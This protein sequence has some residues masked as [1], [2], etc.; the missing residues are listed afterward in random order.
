METPPHQQQLTLQD[1]NSLS[2]SELASLTPAEQSALLQLID[3]LQAEE[4]ER[5]RSESRLANREK[6]AK[7][8][9]ALREIGEIPPVVD[10]A[11]RAECDA[12]LAAFLQTCFPD[13]FHLQFSAAHLELIAAV[14]RAVS[15][16]GNEAFACERGF[17]KTQISIGGALWGCLTGRVRYAMIIAANIDMATSQREGIKRRLET[18]QPLYDLYPEICYPMRTLAGSL[19]MSATYRG[20]LVRIRSRPD[21]V[22]PCIAGAPGSEAVIACTGI[23]SSSIRGRFYDRA[24]G[25]TARPDLVM[26]DDPQDDATARQPELVKKRSIKI[27]QAVTGMRGPGRKLAMLMPCTVIAKNDLADEF[28]DRQRRPEWSGRRIAAMPSMPLDLDAE[29]PLW[30]KYDELRRED[31]AMGDKTRQ[32]AT[33]FYLANREAMSAGAEITWP[34]RVEL[35]CVDALQALM[36]KYLSDRQ[37]FLAEQQQN[38]QGDEDVSAYLDFN[39]IVGRFNGLRRGQLPPTGSLLTTSIDVQEHLLYWL[40]ILWADD[41]SGWIVD[42]GTFPKQPVADFHHMQPPRTIHDWARKAFPRQGMT[43][44]EEHRAALEEC[45]RTLPQPEGPTPGPILVDNRWHKAQQ[46]VESVSTAPEFAGTVVP[47]GGIAVGGNDTAISARKMQ[48]GSKRVSKD[49]EWYIKREST[50]RKIL[51]FDANVYRSQLQKGI[52]EEP[53]KPGSI[54]YN[55]PFADPILASHLASKSV[56]LTVDTKRELEIWTNKPGQDQDHWL[57]C[58]VMCRVAAELAGLRINGAPVTKPQR[59]RHTEFTLT[60][61]PRKRGGL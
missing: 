9:A 39:G 16:D 25:T 60:K 59:R 13:I 4:R 33:D 47:A 35:G 61:Q 20:Q 1:L 36:D 48:P 22:L 31:L 6:V 3:Q 14:E 42:W 58:A 18:S 44:E 17:G 56:R 8:R 34:D 53:G 5:I 27:R 38:P 15:I 45:L 46:V 54:T 41:L 2:E 11:K 51:L 32:R 49:V 24:D 52:A 30:H 43:W 57:D 29:H 23:D 37:A 55:S 50:T 19:K 12:S 7:H 26:L 10:P 40:Q 21:L 28:T